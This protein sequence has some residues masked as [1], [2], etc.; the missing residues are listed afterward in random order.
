VGWFEDAVV[1]NP[2]YPADLIPDTAAGLLAF[3]AARDEA[4]RAGHVAVSVQL[5]RG[6]WTVKLDTLTTP[7]HRV[8]ADDVRV[9]AQAVQALVRAGVATSGTT[10]PVQYSLER[11]PAEQDARPRRRHACCRLR[12]RRRSRIA[13][14]A[15]V[16]RR[17]A[18]PQRLC[19]CR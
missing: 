19:R 10:G 4:A 8:R 11:V 15:T 17:R 18:P 3:N 7:D 2:P 13:L 16:R 5:Q 9:L 14:R 6:R 1:L 12:G